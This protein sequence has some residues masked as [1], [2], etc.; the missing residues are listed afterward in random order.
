MKQIDIKHD[1]PLNG[2]KRILRTRYKSGRVEDSVFT[3]KKDGE[4]PKKI[5]DK[6]DTYR[7]MPTVEYVRVI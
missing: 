7:K 6:Y 5:K 3:P 4:M 1:T 2:Q